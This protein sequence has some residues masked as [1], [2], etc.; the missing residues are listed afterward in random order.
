MYF[1]DTCV[2]RFS[3]CLCIGFPVN[4]IMAN[5]FGN[6]IGIIVGDT[7]NEALKSFWNYCL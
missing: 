7:K 2:P 3:L 5:P 4:Y 1:Y 6:L